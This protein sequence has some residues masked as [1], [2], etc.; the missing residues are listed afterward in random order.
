L[1][2]NEAWPEVIR[3]AV[4]G[5][6]VSPGELV[7][8]HDHAGRSDVLEEVLLSIELA[9]ATPQPEITPP[10]YMRRLLA[11]APPDYLE[12]WDHYR[13]AWMRQTDPMLVLEGEDLDTEG[14]PAKNL[15]TWREATHRLTVTEEERGLPSLLVAVPTE[16]RARRLGMS[17]EELEAK[18]LPALAADPDELGATISRVLETA[19]GGGDMLVRSGVGGRHELR[20]KLGDRRWIADDG[21]ID[22]EDRAHGAVVSNL[23]AGSVYTTVLEGETEGELFLP[24]AGPAREALLRFEHGLVSEISAEAGAE[25][26]NAMFDAHSGEPRRVGH[27]GIGLNPFLKEPLGWTLVD[28]HLAGYVFVSFGENRYMGGHNQSSLNVDFVLPKAYLKVDD[29]VLLEAGKIAVR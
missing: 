20:L 12:R 3:G 21:R 10:D 15:Q 28:E 9:G 16:H 24:E 4:G 25:A 22:E 27:I 11:G 2:V 19:R 14:V 23:P 26:L 1:L 29:R 17:L 18:I 7:Q 5:L 13:Q 8:V 6:G